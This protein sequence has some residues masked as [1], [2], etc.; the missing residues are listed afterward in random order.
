MRLAKKKPENAKKPKPQADQFFREMEIALKNDMGRRVKIA[1][2][3]KKD[4]GT[5]TLEYYSKEDL[6]AIA[7][8]L[9]Q[10]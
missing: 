9:S 6:K 4:H 3:K 7:E 2:S 5:I 1:A 8:K 10:K